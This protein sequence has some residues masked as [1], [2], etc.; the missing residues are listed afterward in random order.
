MEEASYSLMLSIFNQSK[1][2]EVLKEINNYV[3]LTI[4][5]MITAHGRVKSSTFMKRISEV[6]DILKNGV[7]NK[8]AQRKF[9]I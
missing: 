3:M 6:M 4:S 2:I 5:Q 1:K 9:L 7:I 8:Y